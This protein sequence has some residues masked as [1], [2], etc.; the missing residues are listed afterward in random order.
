MIKIT[1]ENGKVEYQKDAANY[2]GN[3]EKVFL[4]ESLDEI[5]SLV[6]ELYDSDTHFT[7]SAARTGLT[8][9]GVP[10][11]G[12][13][14]SMERLDKIITIDLIN[15]TALLEPGVRLQDFHDELKQHN[16]MYP[17]NPTETWSTIGGNVA[18][19]ASGAKTFKYGATRNFVNYLE[20]VLPDGDELHIKRGECFANGNEAE[21]TTISGKKIKFSIPNIRIPKSTKNAA[22]YYLRGDMDLIDLF[23][24]SE[25]TL[26]VVKLI[27][28]NLLYQPEEVLSAIVF[29]DDYNNLLNFAEY[30]RNDNPRQLKPRL[31]ECFDH[32]SLKLLAEHHSD[33]PNEAVGAV[34]VEFE[35]N[36]IMLEDDT[37]SFY[38][39]TLEHTDLVDMTWVAMTDKDREKIT[40]FRHDLPLAVNELLTKYGQQKIYT[41]TAVPASSFRIYYN[42]MY[43]HL[44]S[45]DI[46]YVV[47]GHLGDC[48]LHANLFVKSEEDKLKAEEFYHYMM[49]LA[50]EL[51]GTI[52]AEH[53]IGKIKRPYMKYMFDENE[54]KGMK[55]VKKAFDPKNLL[56]LDTLFFDR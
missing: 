34:W 36:T 21:L 41:D 20:I 4:P 5:S 13:L 38:E 22:G 30:L 7:I 54:M 33:L 43:S 51:D 42:E 11:S 48:H 37:L 14:I 16:L 31:I 29:F 35:T 18:N 44:N 49:K 12:V 10:H 9:G 40:K 27:G 2:V 25:G 23:I 8:G 53:G 52:S 55:D 39:L 28:L 17:S 26:G 6:K 24:G 15:K 50:I 46:D 3:A 47:F 56:A 32:N 1:D 19:N 45:M